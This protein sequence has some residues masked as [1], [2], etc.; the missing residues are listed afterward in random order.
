MVGIIEGV[1]SYKQDE[2][3]FLSG[4]TNI[5]N[6]P[7]FK[8]IEKVKSIFDLFDETET[9]IRLFSETAEEEGIQVRIGAENHLEAINNC[10]LVTATYSLDGQSLGTIG[11]IGPTRMEYVKV[12]HLLDYLSKD[13]AQLFS[14]WYK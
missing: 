3:I 11:I 12:I 1:L 5:L 2:R 6:Q 14:R 9:M 10:S 13:L 7:E 4:A 8:D